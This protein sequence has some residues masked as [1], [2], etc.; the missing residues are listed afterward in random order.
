MSATGD[1]A[2]AKAAR[3]ASR[4]ETV[5]QR[6]TESVAQVAA[7]GRG[8]VAA[9]CYNQGVSARILD[10]AAVGAAIRAEVAAE[11]AAFGLRPPGLA[12]VLAGSDPASEVYVRSKI[13]ACHEL[14][15]HSEQI[16]LPQTVTTEELLAT[17]H[18]LNAAGEIDGIL[19]QLPLPPQVDAAAVLL[20]VDPDKDVDGFH[21]VNVG[22]L[23]T[24]RPGLVPCT[25]AG[26]IELLRRSEIPMAGREAVVV[27]RSDI[28][29]KPLAL[30]LLHQHATVTIAHS[31]T[32][33]LAA[34]CQR[35]ELLFAAVG[36]AAMINEKH[37]R[38]GAVVVDVGVNA[39][40][41]AAAVETYF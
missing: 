9:S 30:L 28:V 5:S 26:V 6:M 22:R 27:G 14:G 18:R 33:N 3:A 17:V 16:L 10:G 35:A 23:V 8:A 13:K 24:Q 38:R 29:G 36:R 37:I 34:V 1:C 31:R 39:L 15:I 20:A 32:P 40:T 19:V 12:V 21:P 11:V 7:P 41:D 2:A 4:Q 25:P